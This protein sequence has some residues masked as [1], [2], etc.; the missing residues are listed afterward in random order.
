MKSMKIPFSFDNGRV[1]ITRDLETITEQ[2]IANVLV[3]EPLERVSIPTYGSGLMGMVHEIND[4]LIF[5]DYR[6]DAVMDLK[7]NISTAN[8]SNMYMNNMGSLQ[9]S[10]NVMM[11]YVEYRLPLGVTQLATIKVAYPGTI[12]EDTAF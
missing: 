1:S 8:I 12:T 4:P 7:D 2:K 3:T 11:V 6:T 5:S 10:K 9:E